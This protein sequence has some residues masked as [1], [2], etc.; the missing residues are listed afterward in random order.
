MNWFILIPVGAV[1]IA[2][3]TFLVMRNVKDEKKF[4]QQLNNDYPKSKEEEGD[5]NIEESLK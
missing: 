4:E 3:V 2:L 5:V 1:L